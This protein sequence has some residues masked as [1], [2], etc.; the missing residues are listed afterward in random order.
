MS[1]R[2]SERNKWDDYYSTLPLV[3]PDEATRLFNSALTLAVKE[4]LPDGGRVLEAGCGGGWQSLALA[5]EGNF[6]VTLLDFSAEAL[7]YAERVFQARGRK[8]ELIHGDAFESGAEGFDLVF[9][10]GVLELKT[11]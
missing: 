11:T 1:T 10:A 5:E 8:V 2:D 9:N 6:D 4:L 7:R 3:D